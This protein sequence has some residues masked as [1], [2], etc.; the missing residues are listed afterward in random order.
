MSPLGPASGPDESQRARISS[1][2]PLAGG[3]PPQRADGDPPLPDDGPAADSPAPQ[4]RPH[5]AHGG[6]FVRP[7]ALAWGDAPGG[8][9][10]G[11]AGGGY[12]LAD[13]VLEKVLAALAEDDGHTPDLLDE[14]A[15][16]RVWVPLPDRPEPVTDGSAVDL[17]LV[18]YLGMDFIPC[19]TTAARLAWYCGR[20]AERAEEVREIPHIVVLAAD[21][22]RC[23]P[24]ALGIA[25]NPDAEASVPISPEGVACLAEWGRDTEGRNTEGRN[26]EGRNTETPGAP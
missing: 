4:A 17:P 26:M 25:L 9:P 12:V 2:Q 7:G 5:L 16:A 11:P 6:T 24:P 1:R 22:A 10:S 3:V 8:Q 13:D 21:L 19:F 23:L 14:L 18:S 15:R 20:R